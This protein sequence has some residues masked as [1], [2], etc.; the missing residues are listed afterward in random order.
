[1][2]SE[3]EIHLLFLG[4][5]RRVFLISR[6][7]Q[8]A[9]HLGFKVI[10]CTA[11][12]DRLD[13]ISHIGDCFFE[14][15]TCKMDTYVP[16]LIALQ[17]EHQFDLIIPWNDAEIAVLNEHRDELGLG[18]ALLLPPADVTDLFLDKL[19]FN[20]WCEKSG[21][22]HPMSLST[23]ALCYPCIV[24]PRFGQGSMGVT[25]CDDELDLQYALRRADQPLIQRYIEGVEYTV[26]VL[27]WPTGRVFSAVPRRR[28]KTRGGEVLISRVEFDLY[29]FDLA[30]KISEKLQFVGIFNFQYIVADGVPYVLEANPRFGGGS[31]LSL[32]AGSDFPRYVLEIATQGKICAESPDVQEGV[33][34]SRYHDACFF[35][36]DP[37][38]AG[39]PMR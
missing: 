22:T 33:V 25:R 39:A 31:D 24:K 20:E 38:V 29:Y 7:R 32:Q 1:M 8:A 36:E 2:S 3:K 4:A 37:S 12:T 34:M 21:L 30:A 5:R 17:Q 6:F 18:D 27:C 23:D 26:D 19:R 11:D 15:P 16:T 28:I 10:I 35:Q 14:L 13:P 9:E